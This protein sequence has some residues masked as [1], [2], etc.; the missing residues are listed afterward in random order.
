MLDGVS[1]RMTLVNNFHHVQSVC[2]F[3]DCEAAERMGAGVT[4]HLKNL[5]LTFQF[6]AFPK[7]YVLETFQRR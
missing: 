7:F 1:A 6:G 3:V 4:V 5:E 2:L